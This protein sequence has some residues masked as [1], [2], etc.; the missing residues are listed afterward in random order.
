ME[1]GHSS[2]TEAARA[3]LK[4]MPAELAAVQRLRTVCAEPGQQQSQSGLGLWEKV[5]FTQ[6]PSSTLYNLEVLYSLLM[7]SVNAMGEKTLEFQRAFVR[8]RGVNAATAMLTRNNFLVGA[9][10]ATKRLAYLTLLKMCKFL[11]AITGNSFVC[12]IADLMSKKPEGVTPQLH[13][14]VLGV[15]RALEHIPDPSS[16]VIIKNVSSRLGNKKL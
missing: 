9:D 15:Q 10:S 7:P 2:L 13:E 3:L 14:R 11:Y 8:A 5:F 6:R 4:L 16:E 12:S 1:S